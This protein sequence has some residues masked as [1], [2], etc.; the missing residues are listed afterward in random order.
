MS[1][2]TWVQPPDLLAHELVASAQEGREVD[3][4]RARWLAAGGQAE[5]PHGGLRQVGDDALRSLAWSLLSEL[6]AREPPV[7]LLSLEPDD[8]DDIRATWPVPPGHTGVVDVLEDRLL[9][10]WLGRAAGCLLG[11][12]VEKVPRHG[13]REILQSQ[14]RWPLAGWFTAEGLPGEVA[15]RWPWNRRSADTSLAEN[16]D[17]MPE[18][19][20]L[21]FALLAL[22][23]MEGHGRDFTT[24]DVAA[25]WL[26]DLPG[27]RVFTAERVAY[28]NLLAGE[29]PPRTATKGNPYREWIGAQIRA[30]VYGWVNPGE[31]ATAAAYAWRD[32]RLSHVRNGVYGAMAV[33]A[34][35]AQAVVSDDVDEV[36]DAGQSVV[37]PRS[38]YAEAL[39]AGIEI[40]RS[41]L[42]DEEALDE[43]GRRYGHLHWV[44]VLNN[45]A[46][47]AFALSRSDGDFSRAICLAVTGGWDTDSV[48]ATVG[49]VCG[50]LA[51]AR[52]LPPR[53]VDPL[54]NRLASSL[55][56]S[57]GAAF[58]DLAART[59]RLASR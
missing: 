35:C 17:G 23:V 53:W 27:G 56:G 37:P 14:G 45:A 44:H 41:D 48:G 4:V 25:A 5:A 54:D 59:A 24:D 2:L 8:L 1:G 34:M 11:K 28:R 19:D 20:D 38:R 57:D 58:D 10:A 50:G 31:P 55:P 26:A 52:R 7:T 40:G 21:N 22:R 51:G 32:A 12:P 46:L 18:D 16:I 39:R 15:A 30:D 42:D 49:S 29:V 47:A 36:L 43:L 13:I 6:D 33:A 9:G 3:D